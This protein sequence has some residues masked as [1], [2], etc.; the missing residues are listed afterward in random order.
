MFR[1]SIA[2]HYNHRFIFLFY[3]FFLFFSS[4]SSFFFFS[5][6]LLSRT[7]L[8]FDNKSSSNFT[9]INCEKRERGPLQFRRKYRTDRGEKKLLCFSFFFFSFTNGSFLA[10]ESNKRRV[11]N[12][13]FAA[14][15]KARSEKSLI[16]DDIKIIFSGKNRGIVF[17]SFIIIEPVPSLSGLDSVH[18]G[19]GP[20]VL[21]PSPQFPDRCW[22]LQRP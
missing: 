20:P 19:V 1:S 14:F 13:L 8:F 7:K 21:H 6:I 9:F 15:E 18:L 3:F 16:T 10:Y 5:N 2:N 4:S 22:P 12:S 11:S 17:V